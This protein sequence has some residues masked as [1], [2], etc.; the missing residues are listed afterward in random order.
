MA[1]SSFSLPIAPTSTP[2]APG[3]G[4]GFGQPS[5]VSIG[6]PIGNY[7]SVGQTHPGV[8]TQNT[9]NT[10]AQ[11]RFQVQPQVTIAVNPTFPLSEEVRRKDFLMTLLDKNNV[12]S[13]RKHVYK[14]TPV[15]GLKQVN[16][17]LH[18]II[19]S[20]GEKGSLDAIAQSILKA[21]GDQWDRAR[22]PQEIVKVIQPFGVYNNRG[23]HDAQAP[24]QYN[25]QATTR[26]IIGVNISNYCFM[27]DI[28]GVDLRAGDTM[29]LYC[30]R[31]EEEGCCEFLPIIREHLYDNSIMQRLR[32]A[33]S[34]CFKLGKIWSTP[35]HG[36]FNS[37]GD[38]I[39]GHKD[40]GSVP[41]NFSSGNPNAPMGIY[42]NVEVELSPS[43]LCS[44]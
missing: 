24:F 33:D 42:K 44:Q 21:L 10:R 19:K 22:N 40:E 2:S 5:G 15:I 20:R 17:A 1:T 9:V 29:H 28:F 37:A 34:Y 16:E 11:V 25:R 13:A 38:N 31:N 6:P 18:Q 14:G 35:L 32:A 3:V 7:G 41:F 12:K 39:V 43:F 36:P 23:T 30:L 27:R 4:N 8:T 26:E